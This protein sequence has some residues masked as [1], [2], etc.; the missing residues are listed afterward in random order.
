MEYGLPE[1][2]ADA[3]P[4]PLA[5]RLHPLALGLVV[6]LL[7]ALLGVTSIVVWWNSSTH[8]GFQDLDV[9]IQ[10]L[11]ATGALSVLSGIVGAAWGVLSRKSHRALHA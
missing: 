10:A 8:R 11:V 1:K 6:S 2:T 9:G 3:R 4:A 5:V 7:I